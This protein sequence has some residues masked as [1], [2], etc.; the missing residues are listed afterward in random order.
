V[1]GR[2]WAA[3]GGDDERPA[4]ACADC[5]DP[6]GGAAGGEAAFS[7][8]DCHEEIREAFDAGPHAEAFARR[9]F[10]D[11]IECHSNHEILPADASLVTAGRESACRRCHAR[12]QDVYER[13]GSLG[14]ALEE[15]D[16][17]RRRIANGD[18]ALQAAAAEATVALV[19]AVHRLA[20][21][22]LAP[23]VTAL[24]AL[25]AQAPELPPTAASGEDPNRGRP[26]RP[27]TLLVV[28]VLIGLAFTM[29]RR[30]RQR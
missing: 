18:E 20:I 6:H 16:A 1:H 14:A 4:P 30:R 22:E 26:F 23:N 29:A 27:I 24:G 19:A 2:A 13:I 17:H 8:V 10:L 25:A 7:C 3:R 15:A 9:G 12:G 11:C 5:H 28:A 21:D